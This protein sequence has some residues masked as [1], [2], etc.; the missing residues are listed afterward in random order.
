MRKKLDA[1]CLPGDSSLRRGME[2]ID[3]GAVEIALLVAEDKKLLGTLTDGDVRRALLQG[4]SL[5]DPLSRFANPRFTSV[6]QNTSR[7]EVLDLMRARS[8]EQ[9]PILDGEGR[10]VGLTCCGKSSGP[11]RAPTGR[12]S[13][14]EGAASDSGRLPTPSP[15]P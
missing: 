8:L 6:T 5:E 13:W 2:V 11:S 9:I 10:V 14:P 15:S 12:W 3:Q 1:L 7:T 4:A